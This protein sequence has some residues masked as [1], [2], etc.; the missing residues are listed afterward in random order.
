MSPKLP[1]LSA[2]DLIK[3]LKKFGYEPVRQEGSHVRLRHSTE[4]Q[5]HPL[6]VPMHKTLKPGLLRRIL[7]DAR[8]SVQELVDVL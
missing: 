1:V 4:P 5:R 8:I 7:R 6:T 3:A 2:D